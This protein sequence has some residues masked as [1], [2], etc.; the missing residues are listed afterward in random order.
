[1]KSKKFLIAMIALIT[2]GSCSKSDIAATPAKTKTILLT[3]AAWKRVKREESASATGPFTLLMSSAPCRM[4]DLTL[5]KPDGTIELNE[6]LLKCD[7]ADPQIINTGTWLFQNNETLIKA[8]S[9][10]GLVANLTV[11]ILDEYNLVIINDKSSNTTPLFIRETYS[12]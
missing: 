3:Q 7:P 1:M 9:S 5:F 12:H 11:V 2:L 8:T 6:G 4:D 10:L